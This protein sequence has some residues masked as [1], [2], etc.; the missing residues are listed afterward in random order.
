MTQ[1]KLNYIYK[2]AEGEYFKSI[3]HN[4]KIVLN[5]PSYPFHFLFEVQE[6]LTEIGKA[7]DYEHL[8]KKENYEFHTGETL[9]VEVDKGGLKIVK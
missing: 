7:E 2:N 1:Q 5:N 3:E 9:T 4:G 6:P 8:I